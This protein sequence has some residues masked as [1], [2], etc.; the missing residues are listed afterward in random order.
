MDIPTTASTNDNSKVMELSQL[1]SFPSATWEREKFERLEVVQN[2]FDEIM[3]QY[4]GK[5][6]E[7]E[8]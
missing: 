4:E 8:G 7:L 3:E 2:E 6:A 5:L 1:F